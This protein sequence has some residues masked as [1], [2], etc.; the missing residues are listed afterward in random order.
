MSQIVTDKD[1]L[2]VHKNETP[3]TADNQPF[4]RLLFCRVLEEKELGLE[5]VARQ[6]G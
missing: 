2:E 6:S 4:F 3:S 1:F 5:L